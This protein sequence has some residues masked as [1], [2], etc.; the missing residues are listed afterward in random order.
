MS[1]CVG[2]Q[3]PHATGMAWAA[4]IRRDPVV[5]LG[6]MGDGATSEEDFH[7]ALNFA[8]VYQVPVVFLCQNNQ[9]A[10]SV[11]VT[12]QTASSTLAVKALAYGMPGVRVDGNDVLAVYQATRAAVERARAGG[13]PT[14]IEALTY[15]VSAHSSSDDPSRYRDES[16][17]AEWVKKDPIERFRTFLAAR[18]VLDAAAEQK[19]R[20][21][22][23]AEVKEA[24]AAEEAAG[25]PPLASLVEGVYA[26]MPWHLREQLAELER[27]RRR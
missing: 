20:D 19:L 25:L 13:G 3:L 11:P 9:W 5:V 2:S 26:E 22:V 14:M 23:A 1:S 12:R 17:T 15:R 6:C 27:V 16:V 21:E 10:I 18:K 24:I 4:K 7:V 8:G